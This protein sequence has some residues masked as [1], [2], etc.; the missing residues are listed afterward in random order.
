[1]SFI[2]ITGLVNRA[3]EEFAVGQL[4]KKSTFTLYETMS[5]IEIMDPK[6][7]SGMRY[8]KPKYTY[9]NL[10]NCEISIEQVIKIIDKLD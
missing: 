9:E 8:E 1:M 6:I 7:D 5:A 4:L 2:D 10:K 3:T